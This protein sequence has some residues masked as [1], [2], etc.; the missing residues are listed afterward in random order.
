[1]ATILLLLLLH[2]TSSIYLP[3]A[4]WENLHTAI[5]ASQYIYSMSPYHVS[6]PQQQL[7]Q[8]H[9]EKDEETEPESKL[10]SRPN[11]TSSIF[12]PAA[13]WENLNTA[14]RASQYLYSMSPNAVGIPE[15]EPEEDSEPEPEGW[16]WMDSFHVDSWLP[17]WSENATDD[18][19]YSVGD[20][21]DWGW[22]SYLLAEDWSGSCF[23][24]CSPCL[25]RLEQHRQALAN[26]REPECRDTV[27]KC[28][29]PRWGTQ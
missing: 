7:R 13:S 16:A 5:K 11:V 14:I 4:S 2:G 8:D 21:Q 28:P 10:E 20:V 19:F 23:C 3:A 26:L 1:M 6:I 15:P 25:A 9:Q 27:L 24:S 18:V 12:L 29:D 22:E 17:V